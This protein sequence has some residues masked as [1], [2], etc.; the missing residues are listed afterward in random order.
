MLEKVVRMGHS[1]IFENP[2]SNEIILENLPQWKSKNPDQP[3]HRGVI[4]TD[5]CGK[6]KIIDVSGTTKFINYRSSFYKEFPTFPRTS[7]I[8]TKSLLHSLKTSIHESDKRTV[9]DF[10]SGLSASKREIDKHKFYSKRFFFPENSQVL[11]LMVPLE[12]NSIIILW[13]AKSI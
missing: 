12:K 11:N 9:L 13:N 5:H 4:I 3:K 1:E 8:S 2:C 7:R 10:F 6:T